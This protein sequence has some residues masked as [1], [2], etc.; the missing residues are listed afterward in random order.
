[1]KESTFQTKFNS[2]LRNVYKVTGAYEL[3]V[4]NDKSIPYSR[5]EVHQENWLQTV[6]NKT[7]VYKI[8]DDSI[9]HK[10]FDCFCL[11]GMPAY[12]VVL[13]VKSK[14]FYLITIN[15]WIYYRDNVSKRK[16]LTE[17]EAKKIATLS[18]SL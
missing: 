15:N 2:W 5:L 8:A 10:P 6:T 4:T 9:G 14:T 16:S 11:S 7:A 12:V 18:E 13:Y 17:S 3:K 1:M